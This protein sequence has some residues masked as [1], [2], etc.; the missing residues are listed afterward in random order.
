MQYLLNAREMKQ[1]DK[2][3]IEVFGVPSLVLME[4]A[5]L[6]VVEMIKKEAADAKKTL[7]VCGTGNNGGDGMAVARMLYLEG[8][9]VEVWLIGNPEK[10]SEETKKQYDILKA[11]GIPVVEQK[12]GFC[13]QFYA[14]KP[15][16]EEK[17]AE[18]Q[19]QIQR[20]TQIQ[21]QTQTAYTL[22][23]DALFGIGL[24][25]N[26]EGIH[27][28]AI[29][30]MNRL[31]G[32]K[33][34]IDIPSGIHADSGAVM[35][36]CF[37]ADHTVTFAYN[38]TGLWLYPGADAAGQIH[39]ADIGITK[40]SFLE[41]EPQMLM[42]QAEDLTRLPKR[43]ADSNKGTYGKVLVIA[44][45]EEMSGAA[46]F[47]AKAAYLSG[48][49]LVK[50]FTHEKN[51]TMLTTRLPEAIPVT[52]DGKKNLKESLI[53]AV[54]WADV[55]VLG[56]GLGCSDTARQIVKLTIQTAAVPIIVDADALNLL[57]EELEILKGPHTDLI[58]TPHLGEMSRLVDMPIEYIKKNILMT[59]QD[60]SREYNVIC[61][62]K[63][64]R[65]ITSIPYG[66]TYVNTS[67]NHGM[68]TAG[69]GDVLTGIIAGFLA[70]GLTPEE[71]AVFGVYVHGLSGDA[72]VEK[73]GYYSLMAEDIL[74][75]IKEVLK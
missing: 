46:Y 6:R 13:E 3:T 66:K 42:P 51:R 54:Q 24:P 62:L 10:C 5:A 4:R 60:F 64:A 58:V 27:R 67:G 38:K 34:A 59:A 19:T 30:E 11:Y 75:G 32:T 43:K 22:I 50:V 1:I 72:M 35:G 53:A 28:E 7:V 70:G 40:E 49:G 2:N 41:K 44:G 36:N 15:D 23:I 9:D 37:Y 31:E 68:A 18:I 12:E 21:A 33:I 20:Q 55:L 61:V 52:Y 57:S 71:A 73:T 14:Q 17:Q 26:V 25:R 69:S 29:E 63:D 56:P 74:D 39:I 16:V 8:N 48:C 65:T 45:S 47:S